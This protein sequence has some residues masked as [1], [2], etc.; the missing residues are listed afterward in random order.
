MFHARSSVALSISIEVET[1]MFI[2]SDEVEMITASWIRDFDYLMFQNRVR[3]L[4]MRFTI[5]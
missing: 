5:K 2:D 4:R 3:P 1:L